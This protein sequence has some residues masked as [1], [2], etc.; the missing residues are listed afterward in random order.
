MEIVE[1]LLNIE[2]NPVIEIHEIIFVFNENK[3]LENIEN[4]RLRE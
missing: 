3:V 4:E 1:K 2:E